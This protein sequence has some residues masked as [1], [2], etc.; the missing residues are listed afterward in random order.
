M[1]KIQHKH[2]VLILLNVLIR[3]ILQN[4]GYMLTV[5]NIVI[6]AK[7]ML[8]HQVPNLVYYNKILKKKKKYTHKKNCILSISVT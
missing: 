7:Q 1:K 6:Q 4:M 3:N 5:D 8:F 2:V